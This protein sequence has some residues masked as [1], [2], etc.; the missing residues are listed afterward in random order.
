MVSI[1]LFYFTLLI[2]LMGE[3][4]CFKVQ[5]LQIV[6]SKSNPSISDARATKTAVSN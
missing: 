3:A 2:H 1:S 6:L 5:S 4:T